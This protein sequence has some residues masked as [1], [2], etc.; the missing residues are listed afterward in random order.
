[1]S[2]A[3]LTPWL[4]LIDRFHLFPLIAFSAFVGVL[5][6]LT[7]T[8]KSG[9]RFL[10]EIVEAYYDFRTQCSLSRRRYELSASRTDQPEMRSPTN[11]S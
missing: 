9:L 10:A 4:E 7:M 2:L 5:S 11:T 8:A 6:I 3:S 1:M